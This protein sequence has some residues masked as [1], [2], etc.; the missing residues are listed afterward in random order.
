MSWR[1][2]AEQILILQLER[3]EIGKVSLVAPVF[4][5][6]IQLRPLAYRDGFRDRV[7][8]LPE[9]HQFGLDRSLVRKDFVRLKLL[10]EA[11]LAPGLAVALGSVVSWGF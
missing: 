1:A 7:F 10:T 6:E 11:S 8:V 9:S 4:V 3:H 5:V 2:L